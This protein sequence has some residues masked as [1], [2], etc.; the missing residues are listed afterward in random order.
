MVCGHD[1][2]AITGISNNI[3]GKVVVVTGAS[4]GLVR[5]GNRVNQGSRMTS[6]D[7][8]GSVGLGTKIWNNG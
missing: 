8:F 5:Q 3:A 1:M 7:R 4:R 2:P 6:P